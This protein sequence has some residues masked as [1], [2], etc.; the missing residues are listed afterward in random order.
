[1]DIFKRRPPNRAQLLAIVIICAIP[2]H[3]WSIIYVLREVPAWILRSTLWDTV[4]IIAYT[5]AFAL[6]ETAALVLLIATVAFLMPLAL[7]RE[8]LV[9]KVAIVFLIVVAGFIV[10]HFNSHWITDRRL[11]AL[12]A[13]AAL[14]G[15]AMVTGFVV[16]H[17][18]PRIGDTA[19]NWVNKAAILA[20]AYIVIDVASV[21]VVIVRN[22]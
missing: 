4:G 11:V 22:I 18:W 15:A 3:I 9:G 16:A 8:R 21:I 19:E 13:W 12:A 14:L 2:I 20:I 5:Q 6:L 1:M 17:R 7:S 10:L